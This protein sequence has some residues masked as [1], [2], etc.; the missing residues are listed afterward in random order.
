MTVLS[1]VSVACSL[2]PINLHNA[3]EYKE[4]KRQRTVCAWNFDDDTLRGFRENQDK[5]RKAFFWI[6]ITSSA[7]QTRK[8]DE[9]EPTTS[10]AIPI[11]A[12]HIS[13][14]SYS[15]FNDPDLAVADKSILTIQTF[16]ILPEYRALGLGRTAMDQVE[17]MATREP[18]GSPRCRYLTLNTLS[19][20]YIYDEGPEWK[21][22]WER[23]GEDMPVFSNQEWYERRGYV[24]WKEEP[25]YPN[26]ADGEDILLVA[27]FMRKKVSS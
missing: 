12:G 10:P 26:T 7:K 3:S 24:V 1:P 6:T 21:G 19:K 4:L 18:Y 27:A 25:R 20:R 2:E 15:T 16:F 17:A 8:S 11:R 13:L 14:D 23:I 22:I 5:G 9:D